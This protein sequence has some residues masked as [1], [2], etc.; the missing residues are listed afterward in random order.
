MGHLEVLE[1]ESSTRIITVGV[2]L[3]FSFENDDHKDNNTL[4][5]L[6][7]LFQLFLRI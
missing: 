2:T 4:V 5:F 6:I 7:L 1:I 3:V